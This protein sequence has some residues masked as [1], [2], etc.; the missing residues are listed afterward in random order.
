MDFSAFS[1]V[2]I[3]DAID[4]GE[5]EFAQFEP[6]LRALA[7]IIDGMLAQFGPHLPASHPIVVAAKAVPAGQQ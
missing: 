2:K 5:A 7:P 3:L 4:K 6:M 1:L